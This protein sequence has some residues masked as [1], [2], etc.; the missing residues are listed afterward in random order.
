M[1]IEAEI[2]NIQKV[3][4]D[5]ESNEREVL[6]AELL[7]E[8][9]KKSLTSLGIVPESVDKAIQDKVEQVQ[10]LKNEIEESIATLKTKMINNEHI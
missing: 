8:N 4:Q 10:Q 2:Q 1:D 5:I 9:V 6:K 3:K 7:I